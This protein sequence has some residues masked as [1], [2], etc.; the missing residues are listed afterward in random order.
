MADPQT[1]VFWL[2]AAWVVVTASG[3][4]FSRNIVHSALYL[5]LTLIGVAGIFLLLRA[6]FLA[7][8][9]LLLYA[10]AVAVLIVF[11]VMLV[12]REEMRRS[13]P[14]SSTLV[15]GAVVSL[16]L[17]FSMLLLATRQVLV[18]ASAIQE[19]QLWLLAQAFLESHILAFELSALLLL[20]AVVGVVL[21]AGGRGE[22]K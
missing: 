22:D 20:V 18:A 19:D 17:F 4:V 13:N 3:V 15:P 6:E 10:G 14:A 7:A 5:F 2:L 9:Q 21:L 12:Q 1:G 8:V 11:A 16:L